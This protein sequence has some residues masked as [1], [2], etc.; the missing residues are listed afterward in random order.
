MNN[1][2]EYRRRRRRRAASEQRFLNAILEALRES[3]QAN[4]PSNIRRNLN[5]AI[6]F[7]ERRRN[8]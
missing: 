8:A 6:T 5:E 2:A 4:I 1:S 7:V 3:Q